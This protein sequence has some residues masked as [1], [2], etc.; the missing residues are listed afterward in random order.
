VQVKGSFKN[1]CDN[2][3][4]VAQLKLVMGAL[5]KFHAKWLG[6]EA[7]ARPEVAFVQRVDA[8]CYKLV[9]CCRYMYFQ[10]THF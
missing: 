4:S 1:T 10:R 7:A 9:R 3:A 2:V 6:F 5:P 8:G